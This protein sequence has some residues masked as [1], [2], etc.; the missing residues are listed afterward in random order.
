MIFVFYQRHH[1]PDSPPDSGSEPP[2]SPPHEDP[3][4]VHGRSGQL[5]KM[6]SQT[7]N[8][9][10]HY[11]T[12]GNTQPLKHL[13]DPGLTVTPPHQHSPHSGSH[14]LMTHN[15]ATA[16]GQGLTQLSPMSV[17]P[18]VPQPSLPSLV[19]TAAHLGNLFAG[20]DDYICE[21]LD[22]PQNNPSKKRK[23]SDSSKNV[24][25]GN[26]L[27]GI[28]HVKQE[29]GSD[30][31]KSGAIFTD[32]GG[33]SPE[34]ATTSSVLPTSDEDYSFDFA[35]SE[36][37]QMFLDST[38]QCIRFQ[39]FQQNSWHILLDRNLKELPPPNY[40][41]DA[42]KGFNFSNADDAFVCQKK[43]H[44]QVTVHVQPVGEPQFVK[45][46]E[47]VKQID[48]FYLHFHGVKVESP[49]QTIKVEQS[50]S[51]RSKKPFYP[52][53]VELASE[54][55]TKTTVGRLHFSETTSNNMRKKGKPNPDQR[56]FYLVVSLCAHVDD[57]SY[58]IIAHASERIIV[59]TLSFCQAS[60]PGQFENDLELCW[61]KGHLADSIY[62]AG[63]VGIN[64]DR[65]EESLVVHGNIKL[66]G[67]IVQPSDTR[68]KKTIE[69]LDTRLQLR[70]VANMR[71][72]KYS[73]LPEF[74][75]QVGLTE[76]DL[77]GTGV[78]AQEIQQILPEAVREIG[79]VVLSDGRE[80]EHFLVVNKER[81]FMENVGAV[82]ELCK[83]TD[84]LETRID[85]LERMNKKLARLKRIDSIKSTSSGS[86][87]TSRCST[88]TNS[89]KKYYRHQCH[90]QKHQSLFCT[91]HIVQATI[92]VLLLLMSFCLAAVATLY[93]LEWHKRQEFQ[94]SAILTSVNTGNQNSYNNYTTS[95][96]NSH[97]SPP[98]RTSP[99]NATSLNGHATETNKP[100]NILADGFTQQPTIAVSRGSTRKP[101]P[102]TIGIPPR[103]IDSSSCAVTCCSNT[104]AESREEIKSYPVDTRDNGRTTSQRGTNNTNTDLKT[105]KTNDTTDEKE[106]DDYSS[107]FLEIVDD[108]N[109]ASESQTAESVRRVGETELVHTARRRE[110]EAKSEKDLSETVESLRLLQLNVTLDDNFC[111]QSTKGNKLSRY[112]CRIFLSKY[113]NLEN[114]TL[115][116]R[117]RQTTT[118]AKC[119]TGEAHV[120]CATPTQI[121]LA[122]R[123]S[124]TE[125]QNP[126]WS[127]PIGLYFKS[128]YVFRVLSYD[129]NNQMPCSLPVEDMGHTFIEYHLIFHRVCDK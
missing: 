122:N 44:F 127:L 47:G 13:P 83:V 113:M 74:G 40:R 58:Q 10:H 25:V 104:H 9:K 26:L 45:T 30:P 27:N 57:Q 72:V 38:Y 32:L 14:P 105:R 93:V 55:V 121:P 71:I 46:P 70:N 65:P 4:L 23:L 63:R 88:V 125:E 86:T 96:G 110:V 103:C 2:F 73:Y 66:T 64:T 6:Q 37:S 3:K 16:G 91:N 22:N 20:A 21:S 50:Q 79:K 34:P 28:V 117:L 39:P 92:L 120:D 33:L 118:V 69:E 81:I 29:P 76:E 78:L 67:H 54:Q 123:I 102:K 53:L 87:V 85:E 119:L 7:E 41:V 19:T 35:G 94:P 99:S 17:V 100:R 77:S 36:T 5:E 12:Y 80:V 115:Q 124:Q 62:H 89:R 75:K 59:R 84:K 68:V 48:S 101:L 107:T 51:D 128:S 108:N 60:N 56:Y 82:K 8:L 90:K 52:V 129:V 31:L 106:S 49:S 42:D 109:A 116:F 61:Q 98:Q 24:V 111:Q 18:N 97:S 112:S 95:T 1:L 11:I 114:V 43:N 126:T 15:Q